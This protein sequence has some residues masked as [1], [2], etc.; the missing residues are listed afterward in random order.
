MNNVQQDNIDNV[1]ELILELLDY[2]KTIPKR[3]FYKQDKEDIKKLLTVLRFGKNMKLK[4]ILGIIS[5][6]IRLARNVGPGE[7]MLKMSIW[8]DIYHIFIKYLGAI[9]K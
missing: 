2:Y 4:S 7:G 8:S 9:Q 3:P 5:N 1:K 6:N